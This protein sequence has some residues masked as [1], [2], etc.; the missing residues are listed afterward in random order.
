LNQS[1][2]ST[3]SILIKAFKKDKTDGARRVVHSIENAE[4][5]PKEIN[6]WVQD[7]SSIQRQP[8]SVVYSKPFPDI[9]HL[10]Q[11]Y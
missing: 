7:V 1:K 10:M 8:P 4:K 3:I 9:D 6:K 2:E 5:N 11:V